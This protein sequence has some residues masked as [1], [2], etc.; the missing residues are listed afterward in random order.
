MKTLVLS[1]VSTCKL[2]MAACLSTLEMKSEESSGFHSW[3]VYQ[4]Q[5]APGSSEKACLTGESGEQWRKHHHRFLV[6]W[7]ELLGAVCLELPAQCAD[8][9]TRESIYPDNCLQLMQH[10]KGPCNFHEFFFSPMRFLDLSQVLGIL[11]PPESF[12][13]EQRASVQIPWCYNSCSPRLD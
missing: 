11:L 7:R 12:S 5:W 10:W 8:S 6:S 2:D 13:S 9:S 4:N 3:P 1:H